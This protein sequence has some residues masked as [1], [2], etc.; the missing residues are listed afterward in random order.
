VFLYDTFEGMPEPTQKDVSFDGIPAA[1]Q[2]TEVRRAVGSWC[3]ASLEDV[4]ANVIST[5]YPASR[6][7]FIQGKVEET[8]PS[9]LPGQIAVLR[10]DTDWYESTKHELIHLFPLLNPK[11]VLIVDDYGHWAGARK[12]VDEFFLDRRKD[13]YF[14]RIDYTGRL[15]LRI[16]S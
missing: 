5:G 13:Y 1:Q 8:I 12:A 11:G 16:N 7:H 6:C 15:I 3:Y 10:L 14:H 9:R 4:K 2:L